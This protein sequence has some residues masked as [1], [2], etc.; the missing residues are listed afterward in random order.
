MQK[1]GKLKRA[2]RLEIAILLGKGYSLRQIAG[3]LDR[4]PNTVSYEIRNNSTNGTYD[5]IKAHA[6]ARVSLRMRRYQWRKLEEDN[7]VR[8]YVIE[9]LANHWNP[10]EISGNMEREKKQFYASKTAIYE[11]LR[12]NRGQYYCQCL[13][14]KRYRRKKRKGKKTKRIM[15]PERISIEKRFLGANNRTRYGHWE[16]DAVVAGRN[17]SGN[18]AVM[19]E[20]KSKFLLVRKTNTLSSKKYIRTLKEMSSGVKTISFTFDNGIENKNH[21][22]LDVPSFFC[23]SYASW[24][25]GGVE[26][27]NKMIRRYI[28]KGTDIS[29]ISQKRI[30]HIVSIINNKPRRI[31][32]YRS[33]LEVARANGVLLDNNCLVS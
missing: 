7:D 12:S 10:D 22:D 20:R 31:L 1:K 26:N 21:R 6:K 25:K 9:G 13:Y 28:P 33:A 2:E 16:A 3:A 11:W 32:G 17:G 5:P 30:D 15:I 24:Q 14:S 8:E 18:L 4:S 27:G 29:K 23:D 19:S